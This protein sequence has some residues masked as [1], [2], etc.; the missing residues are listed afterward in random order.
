MKQGQLGGRREEMEGGR[1]K[2]CRKKRV[3]QVRKKGAGRGMRRE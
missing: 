1:W 3:N 2:G